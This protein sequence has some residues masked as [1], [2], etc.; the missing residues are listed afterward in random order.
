ME[1]LH[2]KMHQY[3]LHIEEL[4]E[5]TLHLNKLENQYQFFVKI[6]SKNV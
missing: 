1:D 5:E 3:Q 6:L 4:L 2:L